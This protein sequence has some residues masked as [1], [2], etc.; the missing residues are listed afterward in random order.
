MIEARHRPH[1]IRQS[2]FYLNKLT[3]TEVTIL[4]ITV[5][6]Y[7]HLTV[8]PVLNEFQCLIPVIRKLC[9]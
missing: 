7:Q 9:T 2:R 1:T 4:R 6:A 3:R 8:K 5:G